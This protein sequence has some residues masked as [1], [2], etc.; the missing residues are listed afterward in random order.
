MHT[1]CNEQPSSSQSSPVGGKA[2]SSTKG[3]LLRYIFNTY[4]IQKFLKAIRWTGHVIRMPDERPPWRTTGG[5]ALS[6]WPEDTLKNTLRCPLNDF[7]IPMG[8]WEQTAQERSKW[9][10]LIDKKGQVYEKRESV[11]LKESSENAKPI[12]MGCQLKSRH[13]NRQFRVRTGLFSHQRTY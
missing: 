6:R 4:S 8:S 2:C 11:K 9:R 13:C 7:D 10:G 1:V 12:P 5:K 3:G